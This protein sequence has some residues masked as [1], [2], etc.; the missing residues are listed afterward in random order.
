MQHSTII[1]KFGYIILHAYIHTSTAIHLQLA[2][3]GEATVSMPAVGEK[4]L[5]GAAGD[6]TL[7]EMPSGAG[8]AAGVSSLEP[9]FPVESSAAGN[10]A[11]Q[12]LSAAGR[13]AASVSTPTADCACE[14]GD[15]EQSSEGA[16]DKS[17]RWC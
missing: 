17:C 13:S 8:F 9:S 12:E 15:T 3:E 14:T 4:R 6:N 1:I 10:T 7:C 5:M 2:A 11:A 16:R